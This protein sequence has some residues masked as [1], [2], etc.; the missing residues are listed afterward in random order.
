[1]K[2]HALL[3]WLIPV[4]FVTLIRICAAPPNSS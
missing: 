1:M 3:T 2:H 4:Y